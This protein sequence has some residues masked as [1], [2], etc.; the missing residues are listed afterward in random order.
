MD[1]AVGI[2]HWFSGRLQAGDTLKKGLFRISDT[3]LGPE[4]MI[5]VL[6]AAR[7]QSPVEDLSFLAQPELDLT[8]EVTQ[9]SAGGLRAA[10]GAAGF[11]QTTRSA[12]A[13]DDGN[14]AGPTTG[15]LEPEIRTVPSG[16]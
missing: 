13:L 15:M 2:S 7:P 12:T 3:V 4:R 5:I 6:T 11:G 14:A 16:D 1:R 10:L 9:A 8:R